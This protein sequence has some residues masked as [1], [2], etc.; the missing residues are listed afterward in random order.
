MGRNRRAGAQGAAAI[1]VLRAGE[2]PVATQVR[3]RA[4]SVE[5]PWKIAHDEDFAAFS[6]GAQIMAEAMRSWNA[7]PVV[8]RVDPVCDEDNRLLAHLWADAEPYGTLILARPGWRL[9]GRLIAARH[10]AER[11]ARLRARALR[12]RLRG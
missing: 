11:L 8:A 3:L 5:V 12:A 9:A 2:R 4:G 6:P 10:E 1:D 7:D